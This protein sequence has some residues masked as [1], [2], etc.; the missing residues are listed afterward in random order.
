MK[1]YIFI[2]VVL[3]TATMYSQ[4]NSF[5]ADAELARMVS[6]PNSPEAQAF[7]KYGNTSV[8]MYAGTPNIQVPIYTI[9]G[10]ELDLPISLSYDAS[11]IKVEQLATQVGL[12]W[13]I[14]VGGRI[15][16]VANGQPDDFLDASPKYFTIWDNIDVRQ[17]LL[18]Y[19]DVNNNFLFDSE[20]DVIDY[21]A[22]LRDI[23]NGKYDALPDYFSF[24]A[25]GISDYFV[26]DVNTLQ[27]KALNNPRIKVS[28]VQ[29]TNNSI[30]EWTVINEDGT[31]FYF[32]QYETTNS[33]TADLSG[34]FGV[35][36]SYNSSWLL[37]KIES[38]NKKDVYELDYTSTGLWS[39]PQP[40]AL[41][42]SVRVDTDDK[43]IGPNTYPAIG[44]T[45]VNS[46]YQI[47]Q[48][49]LTS[50]WYNGKKIVELNLGS[51]NDIH[52]S[53]LVDKINIFRIDQSNTILKYFDFQ[54]SYFK[55]KPNTEETLA[56]HER[57]RLKLDKIEINSPTNTLNSYSFEYDS[58]YSLPKRTSLSQ[59]YLG[60]YNGV[61]NEVLYPMIRIGEDTYDGANRYSRFDYAKKGILTKI[62]YP[63][64]G[65]TNFEYEPHYV[66]ESV[67]ITTTGQKPNTIKTDVYY[68]LERLSGGI[69][70]PCPPTDYECQ[71]TYPNGAPK[72]TE[73][74]FSLEESGNYMVAGELTSTT[75][76]CQQ[77]SQIEISKKNLSSGTWE[78]LWYFHEGQKSIYFEQGT[79]YRVKM[80]NPNQGRTLTAKVW[81]E[82]EVELNSFNQPGFYNGKPIAAGIRIKAI[83]DYS[84][85][86]EL[87]LEKEYQYNGDGNGS[88]F[89]TPK[90]EYKTIVE[91]YEGNNG[92]I[93]VNGF[94]NRVYSNRVA[95]SSGGDRPH[96]VY[97]KVNEILKGSKNNGYTEY[98][99]NTGNN[100][101]GV[102]SYGVPP[103]ANH[104]LTNHA[105]AKPKEVHVY[106]S[107][108]TL[109][110]KTKTSYEDVGY[111]NSVKGLF[112][113]YKGEY[114]NMFP[115]VKPSTTHP[116]KYIYNLV[117]G[118]L[119]FWN[120]NNPV[121][122]PPCEGE[123]PESG[124]CLPNSFGPLKKGVSLA[125][126]RVGYTIKVEKTEYFDTKA[127]HTTTDFTHDPNVDFLLRESLTTDSNNIT[128]KN[129]LYY[130]KDNNVVGAD[131]LIANNRL[132]EVVKTETYKNNNL[133]FTQKTDYNTSLNSNVIMP[134]VI[135]TQ[136]STNSG[137]QEDRIHYEYYNN[138][139]IKESYV[140]NGA[141]TVYIWGYNN[142]LPIAKI[143]NATYAQVSSQ[144]S[145]LQNISDSDNDNTVNEDA[146]RTA[147]TSL[148]NSLPNAMVSTY[149]Y[150]PLIGVTSMTDPKGY[151]IYYK[152]DEFQRLDHITDA[153]DHVIKKYNYNYKGA[154]ALGY[155][156]LYLTLESNTAAALG[157]ETGFTA[158]TVGGSGHFQYAW[159]VDG[160]PLATTGNS[161]NKIF[162]TIG[163]HTV[164]CVVQDIELLQSKEIQ[165]VITV[166]F[167]L[168][169]PTLSSNVTHALS[170]STIKFTTGNIGG[171]SGSRI[172]EWYIN[173][174][175]QN[176]SGTNLSKSFTTGTYIVK[177]R[178]KDSN[179]SGYYKEQTKNI[180][181]YAPLNTPSLNSNI[182][183]ALS[184][185]TVNFTTG[186]ISG[187]SGSRTYEW[188]INNVKQSATGTSFSKSFT[189]GTYS[190]KF[191]VKD[192]N[193]SGHYR[194][195][196]KTIYVY[197]P[198]STPSLT[199]NKTY[200]V[201]GTAITFTPSGIGGGSG[202]RRYE[203]YVNNVKQ[204]ST[205]GGSF[206]K[207]F[208]TNGTYTIKFKVIDTRIASHSKEKTK[209]IY[210]YDPL[211]AGSITSGNPIIVNTNN[212]F[213]INPTKGSGYYSY[214][215][216]IK[217]NWKTYTSTSKSFS[218]NMNYDYY[219]NVT[220]TCIVKDTRTGQTKTATRNVTV[221]GATAPVSK[222][223]TVSH[224]VNSYY[225][226]YRLPAASYDGSGHYTYKWYVDGVYKSS[227]NQIYI[228]LDCSNK[229]DVVKLETTDTRTGL[230]NSYSKTFNTKSDCNG[231]GGNHR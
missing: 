61:N 55:D 25:L 224:D 30:Q 69:T 220:V 94:I 66:K 57:I 27:P 213:N 98:R 143:E 7:T 85:T 167:P 16:R 35:V 114:S 194:E 148:R 67:N 74:G 10:L 75:A 89:F 207:T 142:Q 80:L 193:L 191:R 131:A 52:T 109:L 90:L 122:L 63:T 157:I 101:S 91:A 15:S 62:Q 72:K 51:R 41:V 160:Q 93:Y 182:T 82:E 96:I 231:G 127:V 161:L 217:G 40:A 28:V 44:G 4:S 136:K 196:T 6:I 73:F 179:I 176:G 216:T 20:Q 228:Y 102:F 223:T 38:K 214:S 12:G 78:P 151:T 76:C 138:G 163:D 130:P 192:N 99:F 103:F 129:R 226:Q 39:Q 159:S 219:N 105:H 56:N 180:Y 115:V 42:Q 3:F 23:H 34:V 172:Y 59:D 33:T 46:D 218:L 187:G 77:P 174:V 135:F 141:H 8:N 65:Y 140:T 64:G 132:N 95:S 210:V 139:N 70:G 21:F 53:N 18:N 156:P 119:I 225:Q 32:T 1:K 155:E 107:G 117:K 68:V 169:T 200:I 230:K 188:Y 22:Y 162:T 79:T 175:K 209:T 144:I 71:D 166:F 50:I 43:S 87:A 211:I 137:N 158:N 26:F 13:N 229:R 121:L 150:D 201:E 60:Y 205:S 37:T 120:Q 227:S 215:W 49:F 171:G 81:R 86:D 184:G 104:Y 170:G 11:G 54:Y 153:D 195:K 118:G 9:K 36:K 221:N 185:S 48:K 206:T 88:V 164:T 190:I 189:T 83:R 47:D 204:S 134:D 183:Y 165:G 111:S 17:P 5:N 19:I 24:N 14:N 113:D 152:Y 2:V 168:H 198:L 177:F 154:K 145:A 106:D 112:I 181:V 128:V 133:L 29:G 126:S 199:S 222:F 197:V 31:K 173:D 58:P 108:N 100:G 124:R 45:L 97:G 202:Y 125:G 203:W 186:N 110:S 178:V 84:N 212:T 116:G 123:N 149:T 147:L 208:S 92:N 146:L